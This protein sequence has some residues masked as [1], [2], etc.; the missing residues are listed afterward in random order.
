MI[1]KA[2]LKRD[3]HLSFKLWV[4]ITATM[5]GLLFLMMFSAKQ[6]G[7]GAASIVAQFY[8]LMG[9]LL[10]VFYAG[11]TN[12][13]LIAAQ[14]DNGSLAYVMS[15][16]L[17]RISVVLTQAAFSCLSV[18][19][20]YLVLGIVGVLGI[21]VFGIEMGLKSILLLNLGALLLSLCTSGIGFFA[22][23][24]FNSSG[25]SI[26][27]GVGLPMAFVMIRLAGQ[28]FSGHEILKLCKYLTINSLLNTTD[29]LN[30]SANMVWE[31]LVMFGIGFV[32]YFSGIMLFNK[33]DLPL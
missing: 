27:L 6:M 16:P 4:V 17:K 23:C 5:A 13:K 15:A 30:C 12:N 18:V 33:K 9:P 1:S 29:V 7:P 32:L 11:S 26:A 28:I 24:A 8:T 14:V 25:K 20:M 31:F 21:T 22:S 3:C 19:L 10:F 2:L